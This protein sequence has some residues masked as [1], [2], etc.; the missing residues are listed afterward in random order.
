MCSPLRPP[1]IERP[2]VTVVPVSPAPAS[3]IALH[4]CMHFRRVLR[5]RHRVL[6]ALGSG[7]PLGS[8]SR[9]GLEELAS[10]SCFL[11]ALALRSAVTYSD[12]CPT[13]VSRGSRACIFPVRPVHHDP[14]LVCVVGDGRDVSCGTHP[15]CLL[16]CTPRNQPSVGAGYV[17]AAVCEYPLSY[18]PCSVLC[19]HTA[20]GVGDNR[21]QTSPGG[22]CGPC[23]F[24]EAWRPLENR[25]P[26]C[27]PRFA[28]VHACCLV[29]S[30][31][32]RR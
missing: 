13:P 8:R 6:I 1:S 4:R 9:V 26:V 15:P 21:R 19:A 28:Q 2:C 7:R 27:P 32:A 29:V 30:P 3:R 11:F 20:E 22:F 31:A 16:P 17:S 25:P 14:C 18:R 12:P 24:S 10:H 23:T 5:P